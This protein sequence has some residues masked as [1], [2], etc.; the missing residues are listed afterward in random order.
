MVLKVA[1]SASGLNGPIY[2]Q[3]TWDAN[4]NNPFLQSSVGFTGEYY[5]VSVAGNTNLNGITN[6]QVGDWA[7]FNGATNVWEKIG[8]S[9]LGTTLNIVNDSTSNTT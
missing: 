9:S 3:G 4:A 2:Y 1:S 6:W 7:V 8:A 5:I